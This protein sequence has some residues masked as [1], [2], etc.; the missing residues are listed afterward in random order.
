VLPP[1]GTAVFLDRD[2]TVI[3]DRHYLHDPEGVEL[4]PTAGE[5]IARLNGAGVPVLLVTNQSGIGRG[6]FSEADFAAVQRRLEEL[7]AEHGARLDGVYHCPHTPDRSPPCNC[8]K[9]APGLFLRAADEH[10]LDLAR[11][12]Y[13][14]DRARD[15]E[16]GAGFGGMP[17]LVRAV[18]AESPE[19]NMPPATRVVGTLEE[20]SLLVIAVLQS[21]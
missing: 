13:I 3:H 14:G 12:F 19:E 1:R 16:P 11:C 10:G 9:P 15:V 17:I 18:A 8:R 5:A 4:L 2:G 20:A 21:D 6:L 7:L